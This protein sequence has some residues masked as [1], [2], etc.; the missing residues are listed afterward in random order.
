MTRSLRIVIADDERNVYEYLQ[1]IL[2][3]LGHQ[4]VGVAQTGR[5]LIDLCRTL[6][7]DLV[8]TDIKMPE[9]DG[10]EAAEEIYRHQPVP[11]LLL[12][13]H[14]DP[15]L[16]ERAEK[17]DVLAY[18]I[19]PIKQ[20]DLEPAIRIAAQRFEQIQSLHREAANLR[21]TLEE[22]KIIERAKGVLMKQSAL[23]ED[24]AFRRLQKV[25]MDSN[26]KLID[27]AH[28][29]LAVGDVFRSEPEV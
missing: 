14:H 28:M 8:I 4:V 5:Q 20:G 17:C 13:C 25:A 2:P 10:L 6:H 15:E 26:R 11:I 27:V 12:S 7:P 21:Q 9:M 18:L 16:L 22:R 3:L 1:E 19:K 29:V 23:T 24:E